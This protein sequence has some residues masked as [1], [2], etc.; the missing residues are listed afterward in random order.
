MKGRESHESAG[1]EPVAMLRQEFISRLSWFVFVPSVAA[2]LTIGVASHVDAQ[3]AAPRQSDVKA[4]DEADR[5]A[6]ESPRPAQPALPD[7]VGAERLSPRYPIWIDPKEKSVIVNGQISLRQGM[8]E[9][10]ACTRN[11]KEHEAIVSAETKAFLVHAALLRLGAEP[12]HPAQFQPEYK[13]PEG[14]EIDV[15]V[16]WKDDKGKMQ[17]TRAQEWIKDIHTKKAMEY[18][19]VFGGSLFWKDPESGKQHYQAEG[20]DFVCVSNFGTAMLDIPVKS[21]QS[22]EDLEFEAF[23]EKIPPLGA[24]VQL[25]F[26]PK[27][28]AKGQGGRTKA[29]GGVRKGEGKTKSVDGAPGKSEG[30]KKSI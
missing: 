11:T 24:P 23:T 25:I 10:F 28:V 2:A 26:K 6:E 17:T 27:L 1:K 15:L 9:M 19:F 13:P 21:S 7:P 30:K 4:S 18:P 5:V 20:G 22:N 12:G 29:E 16:R 3:P 8:L 14:T